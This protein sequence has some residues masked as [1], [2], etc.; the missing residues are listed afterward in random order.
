MNTFKFSTP[1]EHQLNFEKLSKDQLNKQIEQGGFVLSTDE[2]P[3]QAQETI[4]LNPLGQC[5]LKM[6]WLLFNCLK[7]A[8]SSFLDFCFGT[9]STGGGKRDAYA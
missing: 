3:W 4:Y 5:Q 2:F 6:S 8:V 7:G 9:T 1:D